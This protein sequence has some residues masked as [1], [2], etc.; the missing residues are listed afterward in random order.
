MPFQN[1]FGN[2]SE[3]VCGLIFYPSDVNV[4]LENDVVPIPLQDVK[5]EAKI[6][7]F[8][9]E[10]T[11]SQSYVNVE[12][13]PVEVVYMFPIEEEAAVTT[14]EAKIDDRIIVTKIQEKEKARE[15]YNEAIRNHKTAVL[16]EETQPDIFQI[17]LGQLKPGAGAKITIKYL[18]ELPVEDGKIKLTIPTTIAPRYIPPGDNSEAASKIASIPYSLN[19]PAPL[20]IVFNG[21]S[22]CK[23]KSIKSPSHEFDLDIPENVNSDGQYTYNGHLSATTTDLDRDVVLYIKGADSDELNKPIVFLEKS[24]K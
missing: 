10:I 22:Q 24:K 18:T 3:S 8:V 6:V 11:V 17:K 23:V 2:S 12:I 16:L 20:S 21:I 14:F 9:S 5:I 15:E 13:N 7:D 1:K 19:R 4:S